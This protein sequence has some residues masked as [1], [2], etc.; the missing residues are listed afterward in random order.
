[1]HF[2]NTSPLSTANTHTATLTQSTLY[3]CGSYC[4]V[5]CVAEYDVEG[6]EL[7]ATECHMLHGD[8]LHC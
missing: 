1:M 5:E 6:A 2:N 8:W 7:F 3:T 4:A